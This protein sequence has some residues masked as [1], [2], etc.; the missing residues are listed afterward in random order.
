MPGGCRAIRRPGR[1]SRSAADLEVADAQLPP[2]RS[3]TRC[4]HRA[5]V[6]GHGAAARDEL[7]SPS[8]TK[9]SVYTHGADLDASLAFFGA[10]RTVRNLPD[11]FP[12]DPRRPRHPIVIGAEMRMLLEVLKHELQLDDR[13][14]EDLDAVW[15]R[16]R[17]ENLF[18]ASTLPLDP[19]RPFR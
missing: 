11:P 2:I 7:V 4:A 5:A 10:S 17:V 13:G 19:F 3:S 16:F 9:D 6:L 15:G 12:G 14:G 1:A 8:L 18:F